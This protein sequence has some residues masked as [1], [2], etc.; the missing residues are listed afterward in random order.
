MSVS[1]IEEQIKEVYD[2][3]VS[4]STISRKTNTN[5]NEVITSQNRPLEEHYLIVWM[6]GIIFKVREGTK[7]IDKT[8]S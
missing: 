7:V 6:D 5:S 2:F 4:S 1:D 8:I 3:E